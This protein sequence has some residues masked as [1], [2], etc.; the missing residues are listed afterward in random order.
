MAEVLETQLKLVAEQVGGFGGGGMWGG[1]V[2]AAPNRDAPA[3]R[4]GHDRLP[5]KRAPQPIEEATFFGR[6]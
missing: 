2:Q 1:G 4:P 5:G 6:P 3:A